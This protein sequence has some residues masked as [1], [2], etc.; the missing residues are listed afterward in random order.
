MKH[1]PTK[2]PND[3]E[4]PTKLGVRALIENIRAVGYKIFIDPFLKG[5]R[6]S[7]ANFVPRNSTVVDIACGTGALAFCLAEDKGCTVHGVD[8]ASIK[9]ERAKNRAIKSNLS[10]TKFSLAD[11]T[12][13]AEFSDQQFDFA[14]ISLFIHSVPVDIRH[15]VLLEATRVAKQII[16]ADFAAKQPT[17]IPGFAVAGIERVAG[18][19]HFASFKAFSA[20]GG[21][22]PL[23]EEAGLVIVK[24]Q[25]NPSG[26]V[27]VVVARK[28]I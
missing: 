15:K 7:I 1:S 17:S 8:L 4:I 10:E 20:N 11:A 16:I 9:I 12:N 26:T 6:N 18:R 27:R 24:E 25:L 3:S 23:L 2:R 19:E 14:T 13:L 22:N 5:V 28:G 21:L